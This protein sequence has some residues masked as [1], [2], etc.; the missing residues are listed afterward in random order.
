M[1]RNFDFDYDPEN[2]SLFIY[3]P[4]LKSKA[5]VE[6]NDIIIDYNT[7]GDVSGLEVLNATKFFIELSGKK[8]ESLNNIKE[9]KLDITPKN[10]ILMIKFFI[11][12]NSKEQLT[13]PLIIPTMSE[14]S[15]A[16]ACN[17]H[18]RD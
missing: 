2:D 15:K 11:I 5:S 3:D 7:K 18:R 13:M 16:L 17:N 1:I 9:C 14:R 12:F 10:N 4:R 8:I 6:L